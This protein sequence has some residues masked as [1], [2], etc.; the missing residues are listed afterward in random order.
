MDQEVEQVSH[1]QIDLPISWDDAT[2]DYTV[3]DFGGNASS[4]VADPAGLVNNVLQSEKTPGAQTWAG[5]TLGTA[6]GFAT[7][8]PFA[9]GAT[10]MTAHVYSPSAG[11]TI[12]LKAEDSNDPTKSVE[13]DVVTTTSGAWESL[14]FD[15]ANQSAGTAQIDFTYTYDKLSIFYDFGNAGAGDIYYL[16]SVMFGGTI[17]GTPG[18]TDPLASNFDASATTDDGSCVYAVTFN[19]DMN[20]EP[21]G[22]FTTPNLESPVFGWCGGCVPLADPDGDGVWSVTVDLPLGPFEY[23][24]AVDAWAGQE[25]LVDDMLAGGTCAPITD[26]ASYANRQVTIV[27]GLST[28]DTY[29]SCDPCTTPPVTTSHT[30]HAGNYYY[31]PNYLV[32]NVGDTVTWFNDGGFHD[33]NGDINSQTGVSFGNPVSFYLPPVSGPGTIG[34]YVFTVPGL[35]DYDCSIGNHAANGMIGTILVNTPQLS[36][37]D[38]PITWDDPTVDYTVT[39]F[40]GT[41]S[42]LSVDPMDSTNSVL[43]TDKTAGAQSWAGTTLGNSNLASS[44]PFSSS[45]TIITAKV[46]SPVSGINIRLKAEDHTNGG[47]SVE[48]EV[49]LNTPNVWTTLVFDFSNEVAGTAPLNFANTYDMLSIFYDFGNVPASSTIFY[50]DSVEFVVGGAITGCTD[51]TALNFDPSATLDDGSCTYTW[52]LSQ[53][54]LPISW[55]DTTVDYTV[56][57]FG[58]NVSSV[59]TDP[60]G[61]VNNVLQS[62]KTPGAATWAGTTLGTPIGFATPIPFN[63]GATVMTAHVYSPYSGITVRL[64]AE[65]HTDPTKSVETEAVTTT[66]NGWNLLVFDF[67][68]QAPGTAQINFSYTYDQLSIFYDFGNNGNGDIYYLD[69]VVF[70]GSVLGVPGCTDPNATNYD[71]TATVDDGSCTYAPP[72]S[73]LSPYC[74]LLA[75]H[76][77][78][79]A[80]VP[81]SIYLT[82]ANNGPNSIYV[83]VESADSDPIDDLIIYSST[84]GYALGTLTINGGTYSNDMTWSSPVDSVYINVLWSKQ[85]FGGNWQLSM[86]D[87]LIAVADTCG[88]SSGTPGCTDPTA[89]N[90][91]PLATIDDGSCT[92][93][94]SLSQIDLPISWDDTTVDYTVSDF[95]GNASSVVA[96]PAG[97]VNNVLQSEKTPG[98]QT[99]AGTTLGTAS[100]FATA[101]PFAS[102]ATTMTAHVY[103][104]SAGVTIKL[105]AED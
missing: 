44:I 38:L 18:C 22:S 98:A 41:V 35:Y 100:G 2:V 37:I 6:S 17:T 27:A 45:E 96:D 1:Y 92:Y 85:S 29:G 57:D 14:I 87:V 68:N 75:Y 94:P 69:S 61:L 20:C 43:M 31:N 95:G 82:I 81:S 42:S 33:V 49:T 10:T 47:I 60:A 25:D 53:I 24:Y 59:V 30:I 15:F 26:Y 86:T 105:K 91:D 54:D 62:E 71:P 77:M 28:S 39:D 104:P 52:T 67:A 63:S 4:V 36:Q 88:T 11:V 16:D 51:P 73:G 3:S 21:A 103:S 8:I 78:N 64:K 93:A 40:G 13:T 99:W 101:I 97:L 90:Y 23:K 66:A 55:D 58:G 65:D 89:L 5:T 32:I 84:P 83:E 74:D 46:Y 70:G 76:F 50:L 19:V 12:K 56:S 102:G 80:E 34:S 7:A 9:S 79:P 72:T 48:T